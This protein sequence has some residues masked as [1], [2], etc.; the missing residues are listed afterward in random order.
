M[1]G[2]KATSLMI[3]EINEISIQCKYEAMI[4]PCCKITIFE[5]LS[6][7]NDPAVTAVSDRQNTNYI[8]R[9]FKG[10][11]QHN[12]Y[13]NECNWT[14]ENSKNKKDLDE[15]LVRITTV[16][17]ATIP[18]LLKGIDQSG[19][20]FKCRWSSEWSQNLTNEFSVVCCCMDAPL[21]TMRLSMSSIDSHCLRT[22]FTRIFGC[23][24][25]NKKQQR[26]RTRQV[27]KKHWEQQSFQWHRV[28]SHRKNTRKLLDG[29]W[30]KWNLNV[31]CAVQN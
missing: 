6:G 31:M 22:H 12:E 14:I 5:G 28:W 19:S 23:K 16:I 11:E 27:T 24:N 2:D 17:S 4:K 15:R 8:L 13:T 21:L 20:L 10:F 26:Y 30:E 29:C 1:V 7:K 18:T 3:M 25:T 9:W